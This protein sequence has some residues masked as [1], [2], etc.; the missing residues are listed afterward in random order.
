MRNAGVRDARK[1]QRAGIKNGKEYKGDG[2]VDG[3]HKKSVKDNPELMTDP[4]NIRFMEKKA[5]R[6]YHK[7][8]NK[9]GQMG[10][11]ILLEEVVVSPG[12][13]EKKPV[14]ANPDDIK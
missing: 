7:I 14:R 10:G 3:H 5:H 12:G 4:S 6:R 8:K 2:T 1:D 9:L 11:A 13:D